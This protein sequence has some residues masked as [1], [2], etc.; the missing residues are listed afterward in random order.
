MTSHVKMHNGTPA[1]FLNHNPVFAGYLWAS[2][3]TPDGY[4]MADVAKAYAHA[5]IHLHAF[6][7]G[8][9]AQT[10]EWC[11]P[12]I[13]HEGHYDF[14]TVE[15]RFGRIL[16]V[17]PDA[18]F[19]LRIHLEMGRQKGKWWRDMYP[20]ECELDSAGRRNTQS[21][22]STIWR[23]QVKQFLHS[24][25]GYL[26][27]TGLDSYVI[28]YQ[29]GAGHTGEW[30]KGD[31]SMW[32][33]CADY[34]I[35][36]LNH[37]RS[38]LYKTYKGDEEA[39]QNAWS[40]TN[41]Q[42]DTAV[43]ANAEQQLRTTHQSFRDPRHEQNVID[44]YRCLADLC[45]DLVID[46]NHTVKQATG[47]D[48]LAGA[49]FGYLLELA[50]N[51]GFFS[52]G[53]D[54]LYSTTQRSGH[55]GLAKVL[56]SPD[57]DFLVSP[58]SYGF[59]GIGGYGCAMP[60]AE[61]MRIHNKLYIFEE[62]SRT[63]LGKPDIGFGR[64]SNLSESTAVLKRNFA[65]VLTRGMGIWW[66]GHNSHI[67][68]VQE[69]AFGKL[70]KQFQ[71]IGTFGLSLDRR[72]NAEIAVLLD[73]ESFYYESLNNDLDIPLIFQQ[74]LWGLPKMGAPFDTYLL[75]DFLEKR[76]PP[77]KLYIF[78]NAFHLD[79]ARRN[80]LNDVLKRDGNVALWI[81]APG[82]I[83]DKPS[84][85]AMTELTGFTFGVGYHKWG[86]L[87]HILD[88][89]HPITAALTQELVWGT[90]N[91]L[92]PVFHIEDESAQILGQV[93]YSQGRCKPGLGVKTFKH[94]TSIYCAAPNIPSSVLRGIARFSGVHI[95]NTYGDILFTSHQL[96]G[97]H[98]VSGGERTFILPES[99]EVVFN[100]FDNE[101][102]A[103]N[104]DNFTT[105]LGPKSTELYYTGPFSLLQRLLNSQV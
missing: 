83:E 12:R 35:P 6:D 88:F 86:P 39:L 103:R 29:T 2:G 44:Y 77:Y 100:L 24:Y 104:T 90:N 92:G 49:F 19:H 72:P 36:M 96:L 58:Y 69:P 17:D 3:P 41:V 85:K 54:S 22:A 38:W 64:T 33:Y 42:F 31:S 68:P 81:Y 73:D 82:Y 1:L 7:V 30:V 95:Y 80:K 34:S 87:M 62:D 46:F 45:G 9:G 26:Q 63:F 48:V 50:W 4:P 93:V 20:E 60:P 8:V 32:D 15:A 75:Q 14:S 18:R 79:S 55:L 11:G 66:L 105:V 52:E 21:F 78:L 53:E 47:G 99:V 56:R 97:A 37:F 89:S 74:R 57:V 51:A 98:T 28:A 70:L 40:D 13:G 102:L 101:I 65:E 67:D 16:D 71:D 27:K 5:G 59:R 25:I 84:L 43:V 61:S 10:P 94:W 23:N 91:R 76:I